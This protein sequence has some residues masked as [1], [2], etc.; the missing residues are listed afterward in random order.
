MTSRQRVVAAMNHQ[1]VDRM[2]IDL[3][4]HM[5]TGISAFAYWRLREHLGLSTDRIRM[6]DVVQCLAYVDLDIIERFHVDCILLEPDWPEPARWSPRAPYTFTVPAELSPQRN[7]AGEWIV[8]KG[9]RSMR[10][11]EGG[12]FFDG[13]W[14]SDWSRGAEEDRIRLFAGLAERIY[15]ETPYATNLVGYGYGLGFPAYFG[16]VERAVR[17][18]TEPESVVEENERACADAIRRFNRVNESFGKHIQLLTIADDMGMQTGPMCSPELIERYAMPYYKRFCDAVHASSDIKV[19]LHCCGSIK[20]F[21]PLFIE[22]GIDVLNP[23]QISAADM[24]PHELKQKFGRDITFWGGGC[25]TQR[26]LG[27]KTPAEVARNVREL[28]SIF[29]P[30]SG[31]VFNQVHN[32]M[33]NVPPENVVAMLDAAYEESWSE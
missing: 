3:G 22:A 31:F 24:D 27:P 14:L 20:P 23:V 12:F 32:I 11:P 15:K 29:R 10:M 30:G 18:L 33:G 17:M 9:E 26:V 13:D 8:R 1:P 28:V 4:S 25:D 2:P 19:F 21:I 16:G 6:P 7:A 5:S